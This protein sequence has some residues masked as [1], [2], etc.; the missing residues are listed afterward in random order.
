MIPIV[1]ITGFLGSGKTTLL[2]NIMR[3]NSNRKVVYLVN[4]FSA[5]D[6]DGQLASTGSDD[7]VAIP[8]GSIFC[9]CLV[10]TFMYHLNRL[11]SEYGSPESPVDA[12]VVEA[13]G[14]SDPAVIQSMLKET[15]LDATYRLGSVIA[16]VD[17][18]TYPKLVHTLPNIINQIKSAD[19]I[20]MNK[21]DMY[22]SKQIDTA[23]EL[24]R[25]SNPTASLVVTQMAEVEVD[26]MR[27]V[28]EREIHGDYAKCADPNFCSFAF[29]PSAKLTS[30]KLQKAVTGLGE[31]LYRLKGVITVD[32][33]LLYIDFSTHGWSEPVVVNGLTPSLAII[34]RGKDRHRIDSWIAVHQLRA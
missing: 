13:S 20:I 16:V 23:V 22:T 5:L 7:V 21:S 14:I 32:G 25:E 29:I 33:Q 26:I 2:K 1:L 12:V 3:Q 28:T 34:G 17:P 11:P 24:V 15:K 30:E 19:T 9:K 18:N 8:G 10:T 27:T 4:E 31:A 6:V